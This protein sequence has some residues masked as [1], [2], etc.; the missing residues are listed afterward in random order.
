MKGLHIH[1]HVHER[2][3][4]RRQGAIMSALTRLEEEVTETK[5]VLAGL[6]TLVTGLAQQIRNNAANEAAMNKLADE[7]DTENKKIAQAVV[8]NTPAAEEPPPVPEV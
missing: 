8:D 7:L 1:V 4:A 6:I 3:S 5:S 2:N